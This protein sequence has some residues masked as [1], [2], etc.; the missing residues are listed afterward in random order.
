[1]ANNYNGIPLEKFKIEIKKDVYYT[2]VQAYDDLIEQ[3]NK[4]FPNINEVFKMKY[5]ISYPKT[6][7]VVGQEGV[8]NIVRKI[9]QENGLCS[10][11]GTLPDNTPETVYFNGDLVENIILFLLFVSSNVEDSITLC[12]VYGITSEKP[13]QNF[14]EKMDAE[15]LRDLL[16]F[17]QMFYKDLVDRGKECKTVIDDNS[18]TI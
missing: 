13:Y 6:I 1:M 10:E 18:L 16:I 3:A 15:S 5:D 12:T 2:A 7:K 9:Y 8:N 11:D 14:K 4:I 17:R